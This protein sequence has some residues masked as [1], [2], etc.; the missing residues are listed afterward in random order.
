MECLVSGWN[1]LCAYLKTASGECGGCDILPTN[2]NTKCEGFFS[3]PP[4]GRNTL[5]RTVVVWP[6][7]KGI[8]RLAFL[9]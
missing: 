6:L 9:G 4:P 1:T 5:L 2:I 7:D 3:P 8:L